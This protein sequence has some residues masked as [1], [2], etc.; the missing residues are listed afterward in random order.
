MVGYTIMKR[1]IALLSIV[2]FILIAPMANAQDA[3]PEEDYTKARKCYQD[4]KESAAKSKDRNEWEHCI[5][6]FED[7]HQ[8]PDSSRKV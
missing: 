6:L 8:H 5:A 7:T 1:Q 4:L 2:S 3:T